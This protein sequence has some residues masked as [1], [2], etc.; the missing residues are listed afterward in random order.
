LTPFLDRIGKFVAQADL[1]RRIADP[2]GGI[3]A[4]SPSKSATWP[5]PQ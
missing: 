3:A 1:F 4:P 2:S 5:E